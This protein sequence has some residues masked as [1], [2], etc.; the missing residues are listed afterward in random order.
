M[1][2][3]EPF[4]IAQMKKVKGFGCHFLLFLLPLGMCRVLVE[5]APIDSIDSID[6]INYIVLFFV[7]KKRQK[8]QKVQFFF[9]PWGGRVALTLQDVHPDQFGSLWAATDLPLQVVLRLGRGA[10]D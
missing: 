3:K 2:H 9:P 6:S 1:L 7:T 5:D 8:L 4:L 10:I